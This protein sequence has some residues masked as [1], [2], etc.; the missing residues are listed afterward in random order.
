MR[1]DV[2]SAVL[3][4]RVETSMVIGMVVHVSAGAVGLLQR[5]VSPHGVA[6]AVLVL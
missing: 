4:R 6:V 3:D 2:V 5:V 1:H